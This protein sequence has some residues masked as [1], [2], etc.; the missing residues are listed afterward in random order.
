MKKSQIRKQISYYISA[1]GI[2]ILSVLGIYLLFICNEVLLGVIALLSEMIITA[3][4]S[5]LLTIIAELTI[6]GELLFERVKW[7]GEV[8]KEEQ[9]DED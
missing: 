5:F 1:G 8:E 3:S 9:N 2:S 4:V 6:I 7:V